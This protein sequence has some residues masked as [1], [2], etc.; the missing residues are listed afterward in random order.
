[1]KIFTSPETTWLFESVPT[2]K[3]KALMAWRVASETTSEYCDEIF[4]AS[5][6]IFWSRATA[7]LSAPE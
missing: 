2:V 3:S 5:L 7:R 6:V 4:A 1:M